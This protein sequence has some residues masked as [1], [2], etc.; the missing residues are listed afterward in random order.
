ME[1]GDG[2]EETDL[3]EEEFDEAE[4]ADRV[5]RIHQV[6]AVASLVLSGVSILGSLFV[7]TVLRR[8][9]AADPPDP[10]ALLGQVN[11]WYVAAI[12]TFLAALILLVAWGVLNLKRSPV[13]QRG[14]GVVPAG[15]GLA[16]AAL[17]W[18]FSFYRKIP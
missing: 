14:P 9:L 8:G 13:G 10:S 4:A 6:S 16:F 12:G 2:D 11:P 1:E 3:A 18:A 17:A 5:G 15:V 7:V